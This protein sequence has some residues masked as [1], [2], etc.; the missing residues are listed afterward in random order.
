MFAGR[1]SHDSFSSSILLNFVPLPFQ[2]WWR[3]RRLSLM[4]SLC[5]VSSRLPLHTV[6]STPE[7]RGTKKTKH[8]SSTCVSQNLPQTLPIT[9]LAPSAPFRP[10]CS[11]PEKLLPPFQPGRDHACP[12]HIDSEQ[13]ALPAG[14]GPGSSWCPATL[15]MGLRPSLPWTV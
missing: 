4:L 2:I 13:V 9:V 12:R 15:R 8:R 14:G 3:I 10:A 6:V 11:G 1:W 7:K 5:P